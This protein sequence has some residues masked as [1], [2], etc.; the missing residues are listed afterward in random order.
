MYFLRLRLVDASFDAECQGCQGA[1]LEPSQVP[2][3]QIPSAFSFEHEKITTNIAE[4]THCT[5]PKDGHRVIQQRR[6][7]HPE[8]YSQTVEVPLAVDDN[9]ALRPVVNI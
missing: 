7:E 5:N 1:N 3:R 8:K 9:S 6:K 2:Q 4:R